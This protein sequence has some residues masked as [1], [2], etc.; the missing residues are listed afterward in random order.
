MSIP[1]AIV[2]L[3]LALMSIGA[4]G[5]VT[6]VLVEIPTRT[7]VTQQFLFV[8]PDA[9][10]ANLVA[11]RGFGTYPDAIQNRGPDPPFVKLL[12]ERGF[13]VALVDAPSDHLGDFIIPAAFRQ[14][15]EHATDILAV[16]RYMQQRADVPIWLSSESNGTVSVV[17]LANRLPSELRMGAILGSSTTTGVNSLFA[18][19]WI[20]CGSQRSSSP[21]RRTRAS[22]LRRPI[23]RCCSR[24]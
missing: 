12:A 21:T 5:A 17:S 20:Q 11:V 15:A 19:R 16:I 13:A 7:G 2:V 23:S 9:P 3:T 6:R 22:C 24:P 18:C 1:G 14:S 10:A 4:S 8:T